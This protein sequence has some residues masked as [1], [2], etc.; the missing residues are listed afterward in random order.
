MLIRIGMVA[1]LF[2]KIDTTNMDQKINFLWK[3]LLEK[4]Q[5]ASFSVV[6][7][8][9]YVSIISNYLIMFYPLTNDMISIITI[10]MDF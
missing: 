2:I 3:R 9:K 4:I 1:I 7:S 8:K 10:H 5:I 6:S